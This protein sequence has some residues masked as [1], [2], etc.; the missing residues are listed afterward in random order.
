[1]KK[2]TS[3]ILII[4]CIAY[5]L[6]GC[7]QPGDN[8]SDSENVGKACKQHTGTLTCETCGV[9]YYDELKALIIKNGRSG[10]T[11]SLRVYDSYTNADGY[12]TKVYVTYDY[13]TS[14]IKLMA[15]E[16]RTV[17]D[18]HGSI[19]FLI[20]TIPH[21]TESDSVKDGKYTWE[22]YYE[23]KSS[24]SSEYNE[25][26]SMVGLLN[27]H[28]FSTYTDSLTETV[29][30]GESRSLEYY[31][32]MAAYKARDA[33]HDGLCEILKLGD[34]GVTAKN[35]GFTNLPSYYY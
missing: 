7:K 26:Y 13:G 16:D 23:W 9:N 22:F 14:A 3:V 27:A 29:N 33:I 31:R 25:E 19:Y 32:S 10:A 8:L 17:S 2:I 35:F 12:S 18:G 6:T 20:I 21:P 28:T 34:K 1:M 30:S 15:Q 11:A 5:F 24:V 4:L